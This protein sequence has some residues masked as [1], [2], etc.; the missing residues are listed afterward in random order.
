MFLSDCTPP[1]QIDVFTDT[2]ADDGTD[3]G[4]NANPSR[5]DLIHALRLSKPDSKQTLA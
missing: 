4:P 3:A 2:Q 5:G 1:F